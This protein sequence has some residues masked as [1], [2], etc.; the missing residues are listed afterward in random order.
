MQKQ[1]IQK[2]L[3]V[4]VLLGACSCVSENLKS[5]FVD[6]PVGSPTAPQANS[7]GQ[8]NSALPTVAKQVQQA[9]ANDLFLIQHM[10][11]NNFSVYGKPKQ[12]WRALITVL[13]KDY[14]LQ[15]IDRTSGVIS[16]DW[17]TYY[18][19]QEVYRDRVSIRLIGSNDEAESKLQV[20]MKVDR[21]IL[22]KNISGPAL[23]LPAQE[24]EKE[25]MRIVNNIAAVLK[26]P[27][28]RIDP[29]FLEV[30]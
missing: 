17:D 15:A 29:V 21:Q 11:D 28:S 27:K 23:W 8:K 10:K 26:V 14:H 12:V 16:T 4:S 25:A 13:S 18:K 6:D 19:N 3:A 7:E 1:R 24:T 5:L 2:L 20:V 22:D 9:D 30:L